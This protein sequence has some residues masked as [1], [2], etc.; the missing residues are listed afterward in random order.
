MIIIRGRSF[1]TCSRVIHVK[2]RFHVLVRR[3]VFRA[4]GDAVTIGIRVSILLSLPIGCHGCATWKPSWTTRRR[5]QTLFRPSTTIWSKGFQHWN[6]ASMWMHP[7]TL[8]IKKKKKKSYTWELLNF[9]SNKLN[10]LRY[11][12]LERDGGYGFGRNP[13]KLRSDRIERASATN[14]S[15][16]V[17]HANDFAYSRARAHHARYTIYHNLCDPR[18][19]ALGCHG[20]GQG[21]IFEER[22]GQKTFIY[23]VPWTASSHSDR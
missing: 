9:L 4:S 16:N 21:R 17:G 5:F 3:G 2:N 7:L 23:P 19:S 18:Y 20:N 1:E 12:F 14:V 11:F 8:L 15:R 6:L 10:K 13:G 22:S